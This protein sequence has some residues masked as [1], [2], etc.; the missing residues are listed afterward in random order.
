MY[1]SSL[2]VQT[3]CEEQRFDDLLNSVGESYF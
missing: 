2:D 1:F 3:E